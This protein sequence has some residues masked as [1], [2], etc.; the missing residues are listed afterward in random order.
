M[1]PP[2]SLAV[3]YGDNDMVMLVATWHAVFDAYVNAGG[4]RN[5]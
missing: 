4:R 1:P 2:A 5:W 3:V